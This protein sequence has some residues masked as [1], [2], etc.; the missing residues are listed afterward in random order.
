MCFRMTGHDHC[1]QRKQPGKCATSFQQRC[2]ARCGRP[3]SGHRTQWMLSRQ[4]V[5]N[6]SKL[7]PKSTMPL[8][9]NTAIRVEKITDHNDRRSHLNFGRHR[10]E[11]RK[12]MEGVGKPADDEHWIARET[13]L[14]PEPMR[15]LSPT[16]SCTRQPHSAF[17]VW[18]GREFE[19]RRM[20]HHVQ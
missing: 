3:P 18:V 12:R 4:S 8:E 5:A 16:C 9:R 13:H 15:R 11:S 10:S 7:G 6:A 20:R 2:P 19:T 1:P 14:K 17:P